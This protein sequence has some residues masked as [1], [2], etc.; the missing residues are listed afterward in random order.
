M[1]FNGTYDHVI[2][3]YLIQNSIVT[4]LQLSSL[5]ALIDCFIVYLKRLGRNGKEDEAPRRFG[6]KEK[7]EGE[8]VSRGERGQTACVRCAG[9]IAHTG[10]LSTTA[11]K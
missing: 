9:N 3:A 4:L 11:A 6:V 7:G 1:I 5:V 10:Y 2:M 8:G